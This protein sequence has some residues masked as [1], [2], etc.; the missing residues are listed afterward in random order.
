MRM[1]F[2]VISWRSGS[3][4]CMRRQRL[5]SAMAT[6]RLAASWPMMCLSSSCTI[7][8]G[9][10]DDMALGSELF[11][12]EIPVGI[13]TDVGGDVERAL[14]DAA[15]IELRR[16]QHR[17]RGGQRVLPA[18]ADRD[19]IDIRLD[20]VAVAGDHQQLARIAD[21]QQRLEAA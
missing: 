18:G 11:D 1:F 3:G 17:P 12:G 4:T 6:A 15:G 2:G 10:S 7:S 21:Q 14:R 16:L 19:R 5:R 9:V 8:R 13:D 20:D